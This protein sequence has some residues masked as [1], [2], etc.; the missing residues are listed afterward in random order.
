MDCDIKQLGTA[1]HPFR[2][3]HLH[4]SV[5]AALP[6]VSAIQHPA[7]CSGFQPKR[8]SDFSPFVP[9]LSM[10]TQGAATCPF[11]WVH[12]FFRDIPPPSLPLTPL[13]LPLPLLPPPL[14]TSLRPR[15]EPGVDAVF[16][17]AP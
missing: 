7:L 14:G 2:P 15:C 5:Q 11:V 9:P 4:W 8:L 16:Q 3:K 6:S 17:P 12:T 10:E 1:P 13:P